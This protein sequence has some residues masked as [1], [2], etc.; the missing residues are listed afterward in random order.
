MSTK[1]LDVSNKITTKY[2]I[3]SV[4]FIESEFKHTI[5]YFIGSFHK[6]GNDNH[7]SC[8]YNLKENLVTDL[9][10]NCH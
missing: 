8:K 1:Y 3:Q 4:I 7:N 5:K 10:L 9:N 2:F 6:K